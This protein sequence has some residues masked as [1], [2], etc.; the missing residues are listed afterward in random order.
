MANSS[1]W[2][3]GI[4]A[5]LKTAGQL[6]Q[7][8]IQDKRAAARDERMFELQERQLT[9]ALTLAREKNAM[10]T[11]HLEKTL[12]SNEKV[13]G[14]NAKTTAEQGRLNREHETNI[15][16][17]EADS[18]V[19]AAGAKGGDLEAVTT[20]GPDGSETT[21]YFRRD[22]DTLVEVP[23]ATQ[24]DLARAEELRR[25][26]E[27]DTSGGAT[28]GSGVPASG[29]GAPASDSSGEVT[30]SNSEIAALQ[31]RLQGTHG[32][33]RSAL[34]KRIQQMK[35]QQKWAARPRQAAGRPEHTASR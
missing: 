26:A 23:M 28:V 24:E 6:G 19:S 25:Q 22:G 21:K 31:A 16:N 18:R 27:G 35:A 17:I 2:M 32:P 14:I 20:T 11:Q 15:A 9:Q 13:A 3:Q 34:Q 7:A 1:D 5:A 4:G 30:D 8:H 29:G 33:T 10:M 12:A